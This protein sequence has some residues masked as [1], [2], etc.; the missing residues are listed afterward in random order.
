[1]TTTQQQTISLAALRAH[2][3]ADAAFWQGRCGNDQDSHLTAW[4][5]VEA[6]DDVETCGDPVEVRHETHTAGQWLTVA[7]SL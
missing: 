3:A 7:E 2:L 6:P 4:A 5:W 1:M